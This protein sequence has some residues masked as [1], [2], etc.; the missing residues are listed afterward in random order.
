MKNKKQQEEKKFITTKKK[1][2]NSVEVSVNKNPAKS[3]LVRILVWII[4]AFTVLT[5]IATLI[6]L[7]IESGK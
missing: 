4:C 6:Y 5:P 1:D 2:D 7:L 3:K